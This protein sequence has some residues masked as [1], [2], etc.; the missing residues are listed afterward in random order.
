M[1]M[2][3]GNN[4]L[5]QY[6]VIILKIYVRFTLKELSCEFLSSFNII[7]GSEGGGILFLQIAAVFAMKKNK[8]EG[9]IKY[10]NVFINKKKNIQQF[11]EK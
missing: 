1:K 6:L 11:N 5:G 3:M 4:D 8:N 10:R 2:I 9:K 7:S